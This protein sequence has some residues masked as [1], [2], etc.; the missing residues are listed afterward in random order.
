MP[1]D[2]RRARRRAA[3]SSRSGTSP[4]ASTRRSSN[5][6]VARVARQVRRAARLA[7]GDAARCSSRRV[8]Y[9]QKQQAD[10]LA[11]QGS[12]FDLG[13]AEARSRATTRRS[14]TDEFEKNELLRDR[15]GGARPLRLRA[16]ALGDPRPAAAQDRRDDRR[17]RAPP[18]R[19]GRDRSAGSSRAVRQMTTK[20]GEAMVFL[21]LEDV[22]GGVDT[23]RLQ[24]DLRERAR[25]LHDRPHPDRQG[26]RRPQGGRDEA[27]RAWR[28]PR[29]RRSPRSA[30]CGCKIDATTTPRR[31]SIRE[32]AAADPA[33]SP[34]SRRSSSTASPRRAGRPTPSA[35][36]TGSSPRPTSTPR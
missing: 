34:A 8:A 21:R 5:K 16:S 2:H 27:R 35:R 23:R 1:H 3:R 26:P 33:T 14:P 11:G 17:A 6:R 28:W 32:L 9:G 15:E 24:L 25:A 13:P 20:R 12:I 36:S 31:A 4:S 30:R 10:R 19:R 7:Q 18:R 29:S 22:T